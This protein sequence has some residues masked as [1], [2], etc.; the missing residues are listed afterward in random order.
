M[1][2]PGVEGED[3]IKM[4]WLPRNTSLGLGLG[5]APGLPGTDLGYRR[6]V[7][8]SLNDRGTAG[9]RGRKDEGCWQHLL[10]VGVVGSQDPLLSVFLLF[11]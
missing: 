4:N 11:P 6:G 1:G 5:W 8:E 10:G 2:P 3:G 7:H 9:T